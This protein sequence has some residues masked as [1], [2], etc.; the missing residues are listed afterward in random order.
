[1][2]LCYQCVRVRDW[3]AGV[4]VVVVGGGGGG[5]VCVYRCSPF[6][7]LMCCFC[8]FLSSAFEYNSTRFDCLRAFPDAGE[9]AE[10]P[11]RQADGHQV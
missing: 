1:M 2:Y 5:C 7:L 8:A 10:R 11:V 3:G 9:G 6:L 4:V